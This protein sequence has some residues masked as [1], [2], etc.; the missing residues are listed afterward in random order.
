MRFRINMFCEKKIVYS[1]RPYRGSDGYSPAFRRRGQ[2]SFPGKPYRVYGGQ[3]NN[4][5]SFFPSTSGFPCHSINIPC[6]FR[7]LSPSLYNQLRVSLHMTQ[8]KQ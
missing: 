6:S 4:G 5:T 3:R 2:T 7:H 1:Y 8:I